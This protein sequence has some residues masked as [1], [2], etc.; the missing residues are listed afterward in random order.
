MTTA[1]HHDRTQPRNIATALYMSDV[2]ESVRR[3]IGQY[4]ECD[5]RA[6]TYLYIAAVSLLQT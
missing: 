6:G 5:L 1:L 3:T 2:A 4:D